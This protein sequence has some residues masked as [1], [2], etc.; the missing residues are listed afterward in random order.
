MEDLREVNI[1]INHVNNEDNHIDNTVENHYLEMSYDF[2][3]R[4]MEK[5]KIINKLQKKLIIIYGLI[6][7]YL[8]NEDLGFIEEVK[9]ILETFLLTNLQLQEVWIKF[10][11]FFSINHIINNEIYK[12]SFRGK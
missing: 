4:I 11:F 8:H 7:R 1:N 9:G 10:S 2:K 6:D 5:N 3:D 12:I